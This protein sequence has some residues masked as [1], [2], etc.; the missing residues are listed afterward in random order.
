MWKRVN[1]DIRPLTIEQGGLALGGGIS[2]A[3]RL[4]TVN[5]GHPEGFKGED[6]LENLRNVVPLHT[7]YDSSNNRNKKEEWNLASGF[8]EKMNLHEDKEKALTI[9]LLRYPTLNSVLRSAERHI[10]AVAEEVQQLLPR[11][12]NISTEQYVLWSFFS[13]SL[14]ASLSA[15]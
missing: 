1:K 10:D 14:A 13:P 11:A 6:L 3:L 5:V 7:S 2:A 12:K 4:V 8:L 9:P 15:S